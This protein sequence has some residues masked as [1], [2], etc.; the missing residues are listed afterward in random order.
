[1]HRRSLLAAAL[2]LPAALTAPA[3]FAKKR[4][5][6]FAPA[7]IAL[8]GADAVGYF[9]SGAALPG[10]SDLALK[11]GGA[12]WCFASEANRTAFEMNPFAYLPQY[13]GHCAYSMAQGQQRGALPDIWTIQNGK[14]YLA[15]S[16]D[17][18]GQF[19]ADISGN[20]AKADAVWAAAAG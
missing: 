19:L 17:L 13:G 1:M 16:A 7:G 18:L 5:R 8:G 20:I 2:I 9:T 6:L 14:L 15:A 11:W 12:I 4:V 3:A 10:R